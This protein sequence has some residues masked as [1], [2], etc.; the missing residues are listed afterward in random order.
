M[1]NNLK[2][3]ENIKQRQ[4]VNYGDCQTSYD[5]SWEFQVAQII[6]VTQYNNINAVIKHLKRRQLL[7]NSHLLTICRISTHITN[8]LCDQFNVIK[9]KVEFIE[10]NLQQEMDDRI[11]KGFRFSFRELIY[12][13]LVV[14]ETLQFMQDNGFPIIQLLPRTILIND[15][16]QIKIFDQQLCQDRITIVER[17]QTEQSIEFM[18]PEVIKCGSA[19]NYEKINIFSLGLI[20]VSIVCSLQGHQFYKD[21]EFRYKQ[22]LNLFG[23]K[24]TQQNIPQEFQD[25][26][27]RMIDPQPCNRP[28]C[29]EIV[30]FVRQ[31]RKCGLMALSLNHDRQESCANNLVSSED[32]FIA[33]FE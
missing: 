17:Y 1:G 2:K 18:A 8:A 24:S 27:V 4:D 29:Q 30:D 15:K 31:F 16:H 20:I 11:K 23:I 5:R 10:R 19:L 3:N 12:I 25:L 26:I 7:E 28:P 32:S 21:N 6:F 33:K 9:L 14:S 22:V 13:T